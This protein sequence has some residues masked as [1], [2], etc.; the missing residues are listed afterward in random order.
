MTEWTAI[1]GVFW[2]GNPLCNCLDLNSLSHRASFSQMLQSL[3]SQDMTLET[4]NQSEMWQALR[5]ML[6][7]LLNFRPT[8]LCWHDSQFLGINASRDFKIGRLADEL[9]IGIV[10]M[11]QVLEQE[12][13]LLRICHVTSSV[14]SNLNFYGYM[15]VFW[16]FVCENIHL[17]VFC[18]I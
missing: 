18:L 10:S 15:E 1:V 13:F 9:N 12:A 5:Q 17:Y 11:T 16:R 2:W 14:K 6:M 7:R 3:K 4:P 8:L